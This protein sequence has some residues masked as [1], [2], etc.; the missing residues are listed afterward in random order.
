MERPD[1]TAAARQ[2]W[3]LIEEYGRLCREYEKGLYWVSTADEDRA[4]LLR[5]RALLRDLLELP[6]ESEEEA[7][8]A[9]DK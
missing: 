6:R 7:R 5:H 9:I 3:I 8:N 4:H 2:F 1:I